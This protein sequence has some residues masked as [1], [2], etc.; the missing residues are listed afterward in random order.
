MATS[1]R[2]KKLP[3]WDAF[4][5]YDPTPGQFAPRVGLYPS[6]KAAT[7]DCPNYRDEGLLLEKCTI[8]LARSDCL[9]ALAR[10]EKVTREAE[11]AYRARLL[12]IAD[13]ALRHRKKA[14]VDGAACITYHF[15]ANEDLDALLAEILPPGRLPPLVDR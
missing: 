13:K 10:D 5:L 3:S 14:E 2:V 11:Q 12:K 4:V 1:K 6:R 15:C 8:V 9:T 7:D